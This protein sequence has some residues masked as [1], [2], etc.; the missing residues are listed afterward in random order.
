MAPFY[1]ELGIGPRLQNAVA[2]SWFIAATCLIAALAIDDVF[3]SATAATAAVS[4]PAIFI[5][6]EVVKRIQTNTRNFVMKPQGGRRKVLMADSSDSNRKTEPLFFE[7]GTIV[8]GK[9]G[10][11][12]RAGMAWLLGT[13]SRLGEQ[14]VSSAVFSYATAKG[15]AQRAFDEICW[16][17][18]NNP[19]HHDLFL[20]SEADRM[21][22]PPVGTPRS[23]SVRDRV[24]FATVLEKMA[25]QGAILLPDFLPNSDLYPRPKVAPPEPQPSRSSRSSAAAEGG[26]DDLMVLPDVVSAATTTDFALFSE[27]K[28]FSMERIQDVAMTEHIL[29]SHSTWVGALNSVGLDSGKSSAMVDLALLA[30]SSKPFKLLDSLLTV[31]AALS[32]SRRASFVSQTP[33]AS[34]RESRSVARGNEGSTP[35]SAMG[36]SSSATP[37]RT[38]LRLPACPTAWFTW[39]GAAL[40]SMVR[41]FDRGSNTGALRVISEVRGILDDRRAEFYAEL[42]EWVRPEDGSMPLLEYF[43]RCA[44]LRNP[45]PPL[46]CDSEGRAHS[47]ASISRLTT[48]ER[49]VRRFTHGAINGLRF[50]SQETHTADSVLMLQMGYYHTLFFGVP[51]PEELLISRRTLIPRFRILDWRDQQ[52]QTAVLKAAL[53][54][55]PE[56]LWY[57]MVD[58]TDNQHCAVICY[59]DVT[60]RTVTRLLLTVSP[61]ALIRN[62]F[63]ARVF[64]F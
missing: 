16:E 13:I 39:D 11:N 24:F 31:E 29:S 59:P 17:V 48:F 50:I 36:A 20:A 49:G 9:R 41:T 19:K 1:P 30:W 51:P 21:R 34:E 8:P 62:T 33:V 5:L 61:N 44:A 23:V 40:G 63:E 43:G 54:T 64:N 28:L 57:L 6:K 46:D 22:W 38:A 26:A 35:G 2:R 12:S 52:V 47:A 58:D 7:F 37:A 3:I 27:S 10:G 15:P 45:A 32:A 53:E 14:N 56:A 60:E 25:R 55:H 18:I 4:W 42:P